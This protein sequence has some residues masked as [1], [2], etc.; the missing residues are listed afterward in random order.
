MVD[1]E[2]ILT[3]LPTEGSQITPHYEDAGIVIGETLQENG[4]VLVTGCLG[5]AK[6]LKPSKLDTLK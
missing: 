2:K 3:Q 5:G 4:R 6:M 1:S